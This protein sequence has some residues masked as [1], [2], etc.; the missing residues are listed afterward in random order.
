MGLTREADIF[1][2][3]RVGVADFGFQRA[4]EQY[5]EPSIGSFLRGST[6]VTSGLLELRFVGVVEPS[7]MS[8][9]YN[10]A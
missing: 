10:V 6:A 5:H 4:P 1:L 7:E 2:E 3:G 8:S 9:S